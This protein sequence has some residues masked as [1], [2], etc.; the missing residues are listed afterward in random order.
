[1]RRSVGDFGGESWPI[2]RRPSPVSRGAFRGDGAVGDG[3][4]GV[5]VLAPR[6]GL[7]GLVGLFPKGGAPALLLGLTASLL[8]GLG[9]R[10]R[11]RSFVAG[12]LLGLSNLS[13]LRL[14]LSLRIGLRASLLLGLRASPF[15]GLVTRSLLLL[16]LSAKVLLLAGLGAGTLLLGLAALPGLIVLLGLR[17][18]SRRLTRTGGSLTVTTAL[19]G[20]PPCS[21]PEELRLSRHLILDSTRPRALAALTGER[22]GPLVAAARAPA[23]P[24]AG[25]LTPTAL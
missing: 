7:S 3:A 8:P 18:V 23:T 14:G 5:L 21:D 22:G 6:R 4:C 11:V 20:A 1:M 15:L 25:L 2:V 10:V 12:L 24:L 17:Q 16:G 19:A 9:V 13:C